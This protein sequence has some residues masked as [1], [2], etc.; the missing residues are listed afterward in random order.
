MIR[1]KESEMKLYLILLLVLVIGSA[2][3][4]QDF[5]PDQYFGYEP[6]LHDKFIPEWHKIIKKNKITR[7]VLIQY[8][9]DKKYKLKSEILDSIVIQYDTEGRPISIDYYG[10]QEAVASNKFRPFYNDGLL[11]RL[12]DKLVFTRDAQGQINCFPGGTET[13]RYRNSKLVEVLVDGKNWYKRKGNNFE[14]VEVYFNPR[15]DKNI[16]NKFVYDK[17]G[18]KV[19]ETCYD[20]VE[21]Y[22]YGKNGLI[23]SAEIMRGDYGSNTFWTYKNDL[24]TVIKRQGIGFGEYYTLTMVKYYK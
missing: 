4:A 13:H 22:K 9:T 12:D 19:S 21:K 8:S 3:F 11:A 24:I 10:G 7:E 5:I 6:G 17:Y 16:T 14:F 1:F 23:L 2:T 18:R 15:F 20:I